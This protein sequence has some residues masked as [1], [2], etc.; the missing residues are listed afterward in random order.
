MARQEVFLFLTGLVQQF[1]IL[2]PEGLEKIECKE[3]MDV[4]MWPSS[5]EVRFLQRTEI[6]A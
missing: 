6:S 1:N 4:V 2:P 3:Q 5:Y